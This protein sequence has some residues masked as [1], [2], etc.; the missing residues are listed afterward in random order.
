MIYLKSCDNKTCN[1]SRTIN[2][3]NNNDNNNNN[4]NNNVNNINNINNNKSVNK[5]IK[6]KTELIKMKKKNLRITSF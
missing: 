2:I 5:N 4:N 1:K 6:D 3:N